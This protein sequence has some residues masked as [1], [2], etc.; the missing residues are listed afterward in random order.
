MINSKNLHTCPLCNI[1]F[2]GRANSVFCS[3]V[4]TVN[5]SNCLKDYS[6]TCRKR[7]P[8]SC[9]QRCSAILAN[10]KIILKRCSICNDSFEGTRQQ[11]FCFKKIIKN[12]KRCFTKLD[13]KCEKRSLNIDYCDSICVNLNNSFDLEKIKEYRNINLW[14]KNFFVKFDRKPRVQDV[15]AYFNV[16]NIPTY[17]NFNLFDSRK[18][19]EKSQ[20]ESIVFKAILDFGVSH[21]D[22][23]R[24]K[25]PLRNTDGRVLELDFMIPRLNL[26]IE[27]NDFDTHSRRTKNDLT[28]YGDAFKGPEYHALKSRLCEEQLGIRLLHIWEDEVLDSFLLES[29]IENTFKPFN[30]LL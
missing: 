1:E 29:I 7:I 25:R 17:A 20:L 2:I 9:S 8:K 13:L 10:S 18:G 4:K 23:L 22:I 6:Y 21:E 5:C 12:C 11:E 19:K 24:N 14:A 3:E 16:R 28:R 15:R 27:V 26:A 30:N